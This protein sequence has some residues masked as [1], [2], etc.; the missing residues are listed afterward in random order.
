MLRWALALLTA[1]AASTSI[2][3]VSATASVVSDNR[4]RG[5][6]L[7]DGKPAAQLDVSYDHDSGWYA[8]AFGSNVKFYR[9]SPQESELIGYAGYARRLERGWSVDAGLSR[10]TFIGDADYDYWELHAGVTSE[11]VSARLHFSPNYFGQSIHTVYG[12]L[13]GSYRLTDRFK[14]IGHAGLLQAFAGATDRA[15]SH[16]HADLLAGI[17][18]RAQPFT[19][20]VGR[21]FSDGAG[22]V[23]PV[24]SQHTG[25]VLTVRLSATF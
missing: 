13:N 2:A 19:L 11:A 23:Y 7:S 8:G 9:G 15:G 18:I 14:L 4:V 1:L 20:Q 6:S 25:G 5:V 17:D 16:P 3:Q 12:E 10:A 24:G 22:R 21:V